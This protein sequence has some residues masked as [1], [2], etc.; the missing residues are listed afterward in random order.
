MRQSDLQADASC[1]RQRE[2][3]KQIKERKKKE[4]QLQ[5]IPPLNISLAMNK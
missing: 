1:E 4:R 5:N 2:W 3:S